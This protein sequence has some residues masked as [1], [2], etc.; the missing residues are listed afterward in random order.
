[1]PGALLRPP[2][3]DERREA[4]QGRSED[5]I[6]RI[7]DGQHAH[8]LIDLPL[9]LGERATNAWGRSARPHPPST[10]QIASLIAPNV[11]SASCSQNG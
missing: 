1:M 6:S 9:S 2:R 7:F 4:E 3:P 10:A 5:D 8:P 11:A